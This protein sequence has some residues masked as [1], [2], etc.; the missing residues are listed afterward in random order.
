MR[1]SKCHSNRLAVVALVAVGLLVTGSASAQADL[2][3]SEITI[4]PDPA[5]AGSDV[6]I[7]LTVTNLGPN[8]DPNSGAEIL[9]A[10]AIAYD[11]DVCLPN[12]GYFAGAQSL[13]VRQPPEEAWSVGGVNPDN[14]TFGLYDYG[15]SIDWNDLWYSDCS[16][17]EVAPGATASYSLT[18]PLRT[19]APPISTEL[20]VNAPALPPDTVVR[21]QPMLFGLPINEWDVA[22]D[23]ELVNDGSAD[24]TMGCAP[25][26]GFTPGNIALLDRGTCSFQTKALNAQDAGASAVV[27]A[28]SSEE[29]WANWLGDG[30][31]TVTVPVMMIGYDDG[32][33]LRP[34][35]GTATISAVYPAGDDWQFLIQGVA[36]ALA[37]DPNPDNDSLAVSVDAT[38]VLFG[39]G[40]EGGDTTAWSAAGGTRR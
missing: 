40:F 12:G 34:I 33:L 9:P 15:D 17:G 7:Q 24:P 31:D 11:C 39:D 19:D 26:V 25:L 18:V 4:A 22:G 29:I 14:C 13:Y 16:L 38:L 23:V 5:V 36:D 28:N 6:D 30:P 3:A 8:T 2:E 32:Q 10:I 21:H 35:G 20:V 1:R 37:Y 27:V